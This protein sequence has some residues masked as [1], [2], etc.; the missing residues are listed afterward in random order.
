MPNNRTRELVESALLALEEPYSEDVT[1]EVL[2]VIENSPD[3]HDEYSDIAKEFQ[4]GTGS[5]NQNIGD[6]V[7]KV[8]GRRVL[9]RRNPCK[10][11]RLAKTYS[12]LVE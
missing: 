8:T 10:R 9:S 6:F 12:K 4:G 5:L 1:D 2:G 11:N 3:M 7:K